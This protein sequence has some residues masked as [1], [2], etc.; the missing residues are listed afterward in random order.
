MELWEIWS[1]EKKKIDMPKIQCYGCQE[2]GHFKKD[3]LKLKKD[4]KKRKERNEAHIT[5]EVE[6]LEKKKSK[7]EEVKYLYYD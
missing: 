2:Y 6:E 7:E 5:K 1:S 4:I 3:F